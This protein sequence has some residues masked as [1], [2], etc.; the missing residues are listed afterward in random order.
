[1]KKNEQS[2][3]GC[4]NEVLSCVIK[5]IERKRKALGLFWSS[6]LLNSYEIC[7]QCRA[8]IVRPKLCCRAIFAKL[9]Q[10]FAE[11]NFYSLRKT[12]CVL[13]FNPTRV[14]WKRRR[15]EYDAREKI[16]QTMKKINASRTKTNFGYLC[17]GHLIVSVCVLLLSLSL[18]KNRCGHL[19]WKLI[20]RIFLNCLKFERISFLFFSFFFFRAIPNVPY[21]NMAKT[22]AN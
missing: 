14:Q 2:T 12:I 15:I 3:N 21:W 17:V 4:A 20:L 9:W 7:E 18:F 5:W 1:M 16:V 13:I 10:W 22:F 8:C 11:K 19:L 6:N